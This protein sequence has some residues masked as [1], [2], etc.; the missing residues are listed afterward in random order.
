LF[1]TTKK[2]MTDNVTTFEHAQDD[3]GLVV[4]DN[5]WDPHDVHTTW[6]LWN[7]YEWVNDP[8]IQLICPS[9]DEFLLYVPANQFMN[10]MSMLFCS[11]HVQYQHMILNAVKWRLAGFPIATCITLP[12][13]I[14]SFGRMH[15]GSAQHTNR[16]FELLRTQYCNDRNVITFSRL[17]FEPFPHF[18]PLEHQVDGTQYLFSMMDGAVWAIGSRPGVDDV[19]VLVWDRVQEPILVES[20]WQVRLFLFLFVF[21]FF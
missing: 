15:L 2:A 10:S 4:W 1:L 6:K 19:G 7:S 8:R 12:W 11:P 5:A 3:V 16:Y 20:S 13:V 18:E 17:L 9:K 21:V 14:M